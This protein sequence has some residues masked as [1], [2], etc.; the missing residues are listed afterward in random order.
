MCVDPFHLGLCYPWSGGLVWSKKQAEQ[1]RG[2]MLE[3]S[4]PPRPLLQ[5]L[6]S[7][8]CLNFLDDGQQILRWNKPFSSLSCFWSSYF[9]TA[10]VTLAKTLMVAIERRRLEET[11]HINLLPGCGE[12]SQDLSK[13]ER[14]TQVCKRI[15]RKQWHL[16][17]FGRLTN[18]SIF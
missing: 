15:C 1:F 13:Q 6:P 17:Q 14:N 10:I 11:C 12:A 4:S 18:E 16:S 2:W 9:N 3:E 5:F 8:S 7:G